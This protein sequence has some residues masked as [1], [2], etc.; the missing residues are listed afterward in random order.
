[1]KERLGHPLVTASVRDD[2]EVVEYTTDPELIHEKYG[3]QVDLV[4]DGGPGSNEA[5]TVID[6]TGEQIEI[7]RQGLGE[8]EW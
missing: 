3:A 6:C 5:S 2:D 4:L 7:V 8:L 1:M